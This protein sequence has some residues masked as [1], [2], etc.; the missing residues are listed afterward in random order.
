MADTY[1]YW[2][3][4]LLTGG[5]APALDSLDGATLSE[6][7]TANCQAC[8]FE[9]DPGRNSLRVGKY[10]F[11]IQHKRIK[12]RS[13][14]HNSLGE[15]S[16]NTLPTYASITLDKASGSSAVCFFYNRGNC[17]GAL[18]KTAADRFSGMVSG[19]MQITSPGTLVIS[20]TLDQIGGTGNSYN[21]QMHYLF[22]KK[23]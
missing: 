9:H 17:T 4:T 23:A 3:K 14:L 6:G 10:G 16:A 1:I 15:I 18:T 20:A 2:K 21:T 7:D 11:F 5:S 13:D 19:I 12:W 22:L 8:R